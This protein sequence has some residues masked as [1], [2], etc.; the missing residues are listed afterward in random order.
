MKK[1]I[2]NYIFKLLQANLF[3]TNFNIYNRAFR[4]RIIGYRSELEFKSKFN[5]ETLLLDGGYILPVKSKSNTLDNPIYFTISSNIIDN[6]YLEL[7]EL[8]S[9]DIFKSLF[10]I[11]FNN[12]EIKNWESTV[13]ENEIFPIPP[14]KIYKYINGEIKLFS[15]EIESFTS[16]YVD[17]TPTKVNFKI[18]KNTLKECYEML[19]DFDIK[20]LLDIYVERLIFDGFLGFSKYRGIASDID[21]ISK[22][23]GKFNFL[24]IKEKDLS[25]RNP[26]FGMDTRRLENIKKLKKTYPIN[27]YYVVKQVNNQYERKF[28]SWYYIEIT[29]F[30]K[31]TLG[32]KKIEGGAGMSNLGKNPTLICNQEYFKKIK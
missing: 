30:I 15:K 19:K 4:N 29:D 23:N 31:K 2:I 5:T 6:N 11:Q 20:M 8:L 3:A 9:Q 24:E 10:F 27:Y 18:E 32:N 14:V 17:K 26:G 12:Y 1:T 16:I 21:S 25:K 13:I 7:Y 22:K 28:K